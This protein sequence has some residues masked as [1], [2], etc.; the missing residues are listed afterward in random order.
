MKRREILSLVASILR[1]AAV[2]IIFS[3][4]AVAEGS[5]SDSA[6]WPDSGGNDASY[7]QQYYAYFGE[8]FFSSGSGNPSQQAIEA[9][10]QKFEAPFLPYFGE[11]FLSNSAN[12]SQQAIQE[13]RLK[14][15][16]PFL[17]YFGGNFFSSGEAYRFAYPGPWGVFPLS[18]YSDYQYPYYY[19]YPWMSRPEMLWPQFQKSWNRTA[20]YAHNNSSFRIYSGE[21]WKPA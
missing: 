8:D 4:A 20:E 5:Q 21:T 18:G 17:P 3:G 19:Q 2:G 16:A 7:Q 1:I 15:E 11:T 9:Q 10:R 12:Q 6:A 14:F 13:Q